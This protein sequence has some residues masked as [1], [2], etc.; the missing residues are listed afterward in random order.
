MAVWSLGRAPSSPPPHQAPPRLQT[1]GSRSSPSRDSEGA[2]RGFLQSRVPV[3]THTLRG[4][5][6]EGTDVFLTYIISG[7]MRKGLLPVRTKANWCQ[8]RHSGSEVRRGEHDPGRSRGLGRRGTTRPSPLLMCLPNSPVPGNPVTGGHG[9]PFRGEVMTGACLGWPPPPSL[10]D[11]PVRLGPE[12]GHHPSASHSPRGEDR[13]GQRVLG[14]GRFWADT[15]GSESQR[16][17]STLG[18]GKSP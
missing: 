13:C 11:T 3:G 5:D 8:R 10:L 17:A 16:V 7:G 9:T 1:Q 14:K 15:P 4:R 2:Q 12:P 6:E 18:L